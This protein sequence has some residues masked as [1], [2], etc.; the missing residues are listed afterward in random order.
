MPY[1]YAHY[2]YLML[3]P[4]AALAFSAY[5]SELPEA[6]FLKHAHAIS[7][8][9]WILLLAAQ[10]ATIH[11]GMRALHRK[12]GQASLALFPIHLSGFLLIYRSEAIRII[13]GDPWATVFG[14]GI[15]AMTL[16]AVAATAYM[17]YAA[18]RDRSNVQLHARWMLV[19]VFLF[20]ES[21]LGR[22]L[23]NY[24]PWLY[25]NELQDVRHVYV[26]FHLSQLL[27][28]ALATYLYTRKPRLGPPFVFLIVVLIAQS[29]ALEFFD[30]FGP[31]RAVFVGSGNW[32]TTFF[33]A[34]GLL[35]GLLFAVLGWTKGQRAGAMV[36]A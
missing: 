33:V 16:I 30:G 32:P 29:V 28:I 18:L 31:W 8:T 23:N 17:Y 15:G 9:M 10:S 35:T 7:A 2:Y 24:V 22:I 25:L 19:T 21:V 14:P 11:N 3:I 12:L 4:L 6:G 5:L 13:D 27:A 26:A 36:S 34:V 20:S 1:R